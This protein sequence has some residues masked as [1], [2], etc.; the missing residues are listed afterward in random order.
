MKKLLCILMMLLLAF[1]AFAEEA[2]PPA[3][4]PFA[5]FT[6]T[7]PEGAVLEVSEGACTFVSGTTR[8]VT[9]VIGRV[10]DDD[11]AQAILRLMYQF[12][13]GAVI[14]EELGFTGGCVGLTACSAEKFGEGVDQWNLMI[15]SP[16]GDLLILSGYDLEGDA[17]SVHALLEILLASLTVDGTPVVPIN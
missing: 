3:D 16:A 12:D 4:N 5:P 8:V 2:T 6:L 11:P 15:L 9:M 13:P 17:E 10:P 7:T 1:P 14:Q